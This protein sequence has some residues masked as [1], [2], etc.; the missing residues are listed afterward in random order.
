MASKYKLFWSEES[1]RNLDDII[2]YLETNWTSKEVANFKAKFS[3]QIDLIHKNPRLFPVSDYNSRL[4]KAVLSRQTTIYY[5]LIDLNIRLV[6][7]FN[8]K[9]DIERIK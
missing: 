8:S 5:E 7:L 3:K 9:K 2:D 6:Y 1:L 4:R